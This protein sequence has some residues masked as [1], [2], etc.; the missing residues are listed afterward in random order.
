MG[1]SMGFVY[2][3]IFLLVVYLVVII[4][5]A[6]RA[7]HQRNIRDLRSRGCPCDISWAGIPTVVR[8]CPV[9]GAWEDE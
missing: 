5:G 2:F 7:R 8:E 4:V 3:V 9:H 6:L 1:D